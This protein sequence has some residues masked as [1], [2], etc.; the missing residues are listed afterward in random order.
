M[1]GSLDT[2]KLIIGTRRT[3]WHGAVSAVFPGIC[4]GL[5]RGL[6]DYYQ[7]HE[8]KAT[9]GGFKFPIGTFSSGDGIENIKIV[10]NSVS[11]SMKGHARCDQ[12]VA[13]HTLSRAKQIRLILS[14]FRVDLLPPFLAGLLILGRF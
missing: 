13:F 6:H 1:K 4:P 12:Q 7:P 8:W 10:H 5:S 11:S 14:N 9:L 2:L 3:D